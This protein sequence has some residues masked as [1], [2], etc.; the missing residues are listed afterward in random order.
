MPLSPAF[1][2]ALLDAEHYHHEQLRKGTTIPYFSHLIGVC[3][4]VLE[5]GGTETEA[6][7]ALFHDAAEDAGGEPILSAIAANY[8]IEV[9]T[10]V[11]ECSDA[12]P[13][14]GEEKPPYMQRKRAYL[15]HLTSAGASTMLVSAADKLHNLRA[16]Y[17][18][19]A[20]IG[21][22]I[23]QRFS[24]PDPKR[25]HVLWYYASLRDAYIN[26]D[27]ASDYRRNRLVVGLTELLKNLGYQDGEF[28][29]N[30]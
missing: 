27:S 6:I 21:D 22:A 14:P 10:I 7:A 3:S 29:P 24:A 19:Y 13:L 4:L 1:L 15:K 11:R 25:E 26:P 8:G 18:D 2:R 20:E 5:A 17:S 16:I 12:T 9:A 23:F 30:D 28:E